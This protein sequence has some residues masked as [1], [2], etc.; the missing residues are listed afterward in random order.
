MSCVKRC[1]LCSSQC[2]IINHYFIKLTIKVI[3]LI[4]RII[5]NTQW[6]GC[7]TQSTCIGFFIH[8]N[9]VHIHFISNTIMCHNN[10][11]PFI[12][13]ELIS[14]TGIHIVTTSRSTHR[15]YG[16]SMRWQGNFPSFLPTTMR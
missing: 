10:M 15:E 12:D 5:S 8:L 6:T 14:V 3:S 9:T 4:N 1:N 7:F 11:F 16:F 13:F 2:Y